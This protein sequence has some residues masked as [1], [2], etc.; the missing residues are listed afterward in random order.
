[1]L[2]VSSSE[3]ATMTSTRPSANTPPV[4]SVCTPPHSL[5]SMPADATIASSPANAM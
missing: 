3:P 5:G 2:P 4:T 1:M